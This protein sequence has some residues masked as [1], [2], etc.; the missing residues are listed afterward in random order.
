MSCLFLKTRESIRGVGGVSVAVLY[1]RRK[2][3]EDE[4]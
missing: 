4:N 3:D 2:G 1:R